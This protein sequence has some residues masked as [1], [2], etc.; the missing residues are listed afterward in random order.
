MNLSRSLFLLLSL[1]V[2]GAA[3][4]QVKTGAPAPD[5]SL[6]SAEGKPVK[7]SDYK[8]KVV[9]LEWFNL[10]CPF[11]RKHYHGGDMQALQGELTGKG[12]V[13]LTIN[14]TNPKHENH[15]DAVAQAAQAKEKGLRST[16]VLLDP[17]GTV[18]HL[19]GAKT[20]PHMYVVD[21]AGNIAYQGAIDDSPMPLGDPKK[22][23]NHVRQAVDE[24]L[25]GRAVTTP[26]TKSYGC[27][28][29]YAK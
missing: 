20:T 24:L 1:L 5:F 2:A 12:V 26:E 16:A 29:K 8:G 18:G 10:G 28:I 23:R 9:V 14:S 7:L 22:A 17:E 27:G 3:Q 4:A 13:W 25:A 15:L 19:Y 21:A 11:V 6:S